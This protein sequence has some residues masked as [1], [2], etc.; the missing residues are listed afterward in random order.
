VIPTIG[1][2][3]FL[4]LTPDFIRKERQYLVL[5]IVFF[6]TYVVPIISLIILKALGVIKSFQVESIKERKIPLFLMLLI[7]YIL[8]WFLIMIPDFKD[9]GVLFYGTNLSL[10]VIYILFFFNI[11]TSLHI[12]SMSSALGFFLIYGTLNSIS[13]LP[14]AVIIIMLTGLLA[15]SRLYLKAHTPLEVYLGFF[16][17]ITSQYVGYLLL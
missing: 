14:I 8:G 12:V 3:L 11:K 15:S 6:S 1:V 4:A 2:L 7:F 9:L 5:G 10:I 16:L 17:G 13:I